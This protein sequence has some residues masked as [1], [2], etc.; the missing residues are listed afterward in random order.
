MA[1]PKP[2]P[3]R[4]DQ[5][6]RKAGEGHRGAGRA[7]PGRWTVRLA[8]GSAEIAVATDAAGATTYKP[9]HILIGEVL[10][11]SVEWPLAQ[12]SI[13]RLQPADSPGAS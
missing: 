13:E 8:F 12:R 7:A 2:R 9:L 3:A 10:A 5:G 11:S 1:N 4:R 6:P